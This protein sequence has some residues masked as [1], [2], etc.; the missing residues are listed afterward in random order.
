[1]GSALPVNVAE[2]VMQRLKNG[3]IKVLSEK[4]LFW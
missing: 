4:I 2:I 1:M 3:I